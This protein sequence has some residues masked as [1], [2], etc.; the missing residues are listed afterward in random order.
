MKKIVIKNAVIAFIHEGSS[1]LDDRAFTALSISDKTQVMSE[2]PAPFLY[3]ESFS[4]LS[5]LGT[6]K[7]KL[8][9]GK[10]VSLELAYNG[11]DLPSEFS[12][13]R[14]RY[15]DVLAPVLAQ[16][17]GLRPIYPFAEIP[18]DRTV[19]KVSGEWAVRASYKV[20]ITLLK[21]IWGR[22]SPRWAKHWSDANIKIDG[23]R[24]A[25]SS[26]EH[27]YEDGSAIDNNSSR[28]V[29]YAANSIAIGCQ[30]ISRYEL[31]QFALSQGWAF[32]A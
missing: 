21:K 19:V 26:L 22:V 20:K 15:L 11:I 17:E 25:W 23:K 9:D 1:V 6:I 24:K 30:N 28:Y 31:E 27:T 5:N 4:Q 16:I 8:F 2:L 14:Q 32:P 3:V 18:E 10:D 7:K 29:E 12:S 13:V